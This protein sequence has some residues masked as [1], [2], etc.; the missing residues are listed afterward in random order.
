VCTSGEEADTAGS[1]VDH[2]GDY[3]EENSTKVR[4]IF[5]FIGIMMNSC[6]FT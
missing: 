2:D 3:T 5:G 4:Y 6:E 1:A